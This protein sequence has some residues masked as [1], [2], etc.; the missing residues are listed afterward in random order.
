MEIVLLVLQIVGTVAFAIS[1]S[2]AAIKAK[3]DLL[4]TLI[5]GCITAVGSGML[6]DIIMVQLPALF[7][8]TYLVAI[9]AGVSLLT[10]FIVYFSR[11]KIKDFTIFEKI[12]N[13]FD[14]VGLAVFT[15]V[16]CEMA[17]SHFYVSQNVFLS[18]TL[19][20]LTAVGGGL[21]RDVLTNTPP[22]ILHKHI[23]AVA[24]L[25][26]ATLFYLLRRFTTQSIVATIVGMVVI[27]LLRVLA[28][29]F[30]WSLPKIKEV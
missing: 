8:D 17:F 9:A 14:A 4:G 20:V 21:L 10:F 5:V 2:I 28:T 1:G 18:L 3:C 24:S 15:V 22:Y 23:Y 6:R 11:G 7:T 27:V 19:G 30:K 25:A 29:R 12:N 26:G 16:G 13:Y